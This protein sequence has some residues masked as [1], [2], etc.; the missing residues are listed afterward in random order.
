[1]TNPFAG[2]ESGMAALMS[3]MIPADVLE[4]IQIAKTQLPQ[5]IDSVQSAVSR[6]ESKLD[7][8]LVAVA[9]IKLHLDPTSIP[10][11]LPVMLPD[12]KLLISGDIVQVQSEVKETDKN[13]HN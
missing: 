3:S 1:M 6:I 5:V 12:G 13:K 9:A 11:N 2:K 8:L 7:V 4:A 10:D